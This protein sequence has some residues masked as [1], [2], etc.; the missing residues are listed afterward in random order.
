MSSAPGQ[1]VVESVEYESVVTV[2]AFNLA[3]TR[4]L[5]NVECELWNESNLWDWHMLGCRVDQAD[6]ALAARPGAGNLQGSRQV[7]LHTAC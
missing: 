1:D 6:D 7:G 5:H 4:H 3:H 2:A